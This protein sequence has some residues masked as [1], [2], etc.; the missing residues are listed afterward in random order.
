MQKKKNHDGFFK[1]H[2]IHIEMHMDRPDKSENTFGIN[3]NYRIVAR[4]STC[5]NSG[6]KKF[7]KKISIIFYPDRSLSELFSKQNTISRPRLSEIDPDWSFCVAYI[8]LNMYRGSPDSTDFGAKGNRTNVK[9]ALI[10]DWFS[11]KTVKWGK[12]NF[13][14]HFLTE[15]FFQNCCWSN[16]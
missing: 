12:L 2:F 7:A 14:V 8:Y 15:S 9:T 13:K 4:R 3:I 10:G 6:N 11:T 1:I 5:Y 16:Y